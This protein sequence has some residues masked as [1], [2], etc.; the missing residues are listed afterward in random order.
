MLGDE[1]FWRQL[2]VGDG[3]DHLSHQDPLSIYIS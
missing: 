3:F 2:Y 1:I